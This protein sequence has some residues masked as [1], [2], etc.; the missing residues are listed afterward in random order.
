VAHPDP[1]RFAVALSKDG[2]RWRR[3]VRNLRQPFCS[4]VLQA[5]ALDA[6]G[7]E[8]AFHIGWR[9]FSFANPFDYKQTTASTKTPSPTMTPFLLFRSVSNVTF[10]LK[11][12]K[13]TMDSF[14]LSGLT[15]IRPSN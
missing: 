3:L 10:C 9:L 2:W 12:G 7:T 1:L 14:Q 11:R 4:R 5:Q 6:F 15:R 13:V 8:L